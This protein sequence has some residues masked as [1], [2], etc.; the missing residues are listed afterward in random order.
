MTDL[1]L[2]AAFRK[3]MRPI[4]TRRA[5]RELALAALLLFGFLLAPRAQGQP[6]PGSV[7]PRLQLIWSGTLTSHQNLNTNASPPSAWSNTIANTN[8]A[9]F[10]NTLLM[11]IGS[12]PIGLELYVTNTNTFAAASNLTINAYRA[13]DLTGGNSS[14]IGI[15]YGLLFESNAFFNWQPAYQTSALQATNI[16][17]SLWEPGTSIGYTFSNNTLS[18][19]SI[20]LYQIVA[21]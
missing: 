1:K 20:A 13:F 6:V 2:F 15:A 12:H 9:G 17:T 8:I 5:N 7:R 19:I 4:Q 3:I 18:N 11:A 21:P 10:S 14:G 16:P